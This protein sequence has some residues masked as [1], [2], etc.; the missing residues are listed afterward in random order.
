MHTKC[1]IIIVKISFY[2]KK[3][4]CIYRIKYDVKLNELLILY[5]F[6]KPKKK[7]IADKIIIKS[8]FFFLHKLCINYGVEIY[9][10]EFIV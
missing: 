1:I 7:K 8:F 3:K 5:K 6:E 9:M 2:I 10:H 4:I